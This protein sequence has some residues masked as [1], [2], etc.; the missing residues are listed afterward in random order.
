MRRLGRGWAP[1]FVKV[2][3]DNQVTEVIVQLSTVIEGRFPGR[4]LKGRSTRNQ[5]VVFKCI[6]WEQTEGERGHHI[7]GLGR[8]HQRH[9]LRHPRFGLALNYLALQSDRRYPHASRITSRFALENRRVGCQPDR[10][11]RRTSPF[12][13]LPALQSNCFNQ[14]GISRDGGS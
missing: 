10:G 12:R 2:G 14:R 5:P 13:G 8:I 7:Y 1:A 3:R 4:I 11:K 6:V 9:W